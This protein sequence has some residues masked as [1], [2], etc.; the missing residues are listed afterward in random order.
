MV[1]E[2][3]SHAPYGHIR[4]LE[5]WFVP[6]S[7]PRAGGGSTAPLGGYIDLTGIGLGDVTG[8]GL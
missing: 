8:R 3:R 4:L 6:L 2:H 7:S 5:W 1:R